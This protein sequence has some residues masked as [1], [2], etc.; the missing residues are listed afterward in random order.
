MK[1]IA[2]VMQPRAQD[3]EEE[4]SDLLRCEALLQLADLMVHHGTM[5]GLLRELAARLHSV[6]V[7]EVATVSLHDASR[8][9]MH[10]HTWEGGESLSVPSEVGLEESA[11]GWVWRHQEPLLLSDLRKETRFAPILDKLR[12]RG[13]RTYCMLPLTTSQNRLG[14]LGFGSSQP[15][16]YGTKD[17][18]FL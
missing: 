3:A 12:A 2:V 9:V 1:P 6:A 18:E 17:L 11:S 13:I 4:N 10:V 14:A 7:F 15:E 5:A 8:D 16:A